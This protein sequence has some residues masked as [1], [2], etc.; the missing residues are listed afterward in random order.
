MIKSAL[1]LDLAAYSD[2]TGGGVEL[3]IARPSSL[4]PRPCS[5]LRQLVVVAHDAR[6]LPAVAFLLPQMEKL[7]GLGHPVRLA[8]LNRIEIVPAGFHR[9]IFVERID[10]QAAF[11]QFPAGTKIHALFDA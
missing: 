2:A 9:A 4:A 1:A 11:D 8:C 7:G 10:R 6:Q 5:S 3:L